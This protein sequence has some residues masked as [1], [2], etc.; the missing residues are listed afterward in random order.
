MILDYAI[1]ELLATQADVELGYAEFI[2]Q[3]LT[4]D[5]ET[6]AFLF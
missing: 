5:A 2:G 3:I 4:F 1:N 6:G